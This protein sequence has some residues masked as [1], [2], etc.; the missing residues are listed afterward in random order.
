[1]MRDKLMVIL[2]RASIRHVNT[3]R[4][5]VLASGRNKWNQIRSSRMSARTKW[6]ACG[7]GL[8]SMPLPVKSGAGCWMRPW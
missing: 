1:M 3:W 4:W 8:L 6:A 7:A 2:S 5:Q